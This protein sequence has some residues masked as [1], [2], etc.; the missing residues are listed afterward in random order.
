VDEE[1]LRPV[2]FIKVTENFFARREEDNKIYRNMITIHSDGFMT[3]TS[4]SEDINANKAEEAYQVLKKI[5]KDSGQQVVVKVE[6]T[7]EIGST[8]F[9]KYTEY[10]IEVK[11]LDLKKLL[12]MRFSNVSDM[13]SAMQAHYKD[14]LKITEDDS[15]KKSWFNSHKSKIIEA[16]K[17]T[18]CQIF[19]RLFNHP[20][21]KR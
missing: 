7:E 17:L 2:K 11:Y 21:I 16:R 12:H 14:P 15:L 10:I 19:Q 13:V 4:G 18:I 8:S 5:T 6:G 1:T 9:A 3:F 20:L